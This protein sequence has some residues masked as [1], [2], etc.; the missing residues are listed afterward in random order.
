M[1]KKRR[2]KGDPCDNIEDFQMMDIDDINPPSSVLTAASS[3]STLFN[4]SQW[5]IHGDRIHQTSSLASIEDPVAVKASSATDSTTTPL[6]TDSSTIEVESTATFDFIEVES[7]FHNAN[8]EE[9]ISPECDRSAKRSFLGVSHLCLTSIM[10]AHI[11]IYFSFL[12]ITRCWHGS[13][14]PKTFFLSSLDWMVG[15][16]TKIN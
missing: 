9:E 10:E 3:T 13:S 2:R 6:A 7:T 15:A 8:A 12:R 11:C 1:P 5:D 14:T 4:I 16:N